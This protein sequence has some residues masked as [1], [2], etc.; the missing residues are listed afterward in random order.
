MNLVCRLDPVYHKRQ[1]K[2][3]DVAQL[4]EGKPSTHGSWVWAL[5]QH[6]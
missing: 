5:A 1:S 6:A 4:V 3:G 2:A